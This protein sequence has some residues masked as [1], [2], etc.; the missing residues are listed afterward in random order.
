MPRGLNL[1]DGMSYWFE[2]ITFKQYRF[3]GFGY[4]CRFNRQ[5]LLMK[6]FMNTLIKAAEREKS[7]EGFM[8]NTAKIIKSYL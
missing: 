7:K 8:S 6:Y 5:N 1:I 4:D 3:V 2:F